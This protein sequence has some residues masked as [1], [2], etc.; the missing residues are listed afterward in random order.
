G[1]SGSHTFVHD[2]IQLA[3]RAACSHSPSAATRAASRAEFWARGADELS[4]STMSQRPSRGLR[5][6]RQAFNHG[7]DAALLGVGCHLSSQ[8]GSRGAAP[9]DHWN[10]DLWGG[11]G[12]GFT[13]HQIGLSAPVVTLIAC[14]F[15]RD[16]IDPLARKLPV[17]VVITGRQH[18]PG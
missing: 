14:L 9:V 8:G 15:G 11:I 3:W 4:V 5:D 7:I 2:R 13:R 16:V 18:T 17:D 10:R 1:G 6:P 12:G